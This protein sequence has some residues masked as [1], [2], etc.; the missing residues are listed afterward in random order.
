MH[1]YHGTTARAAREILRTG[2][3]PRK[4]SD[5]N[6]A[7][8]G[9]STQPIAVYLEGE[10]EKARYWAN[11]ACAPDDEPAIIAIDAAETL[12]IYPDTEAKSKTSYF[13]PC[14]IAPHLLTMVT[15]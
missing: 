1:L 2:L 3:M 4:P 9:V 6:H 11:W 14:A 15:L 7:G 13:T 8:E 5:G 10:L 12:R